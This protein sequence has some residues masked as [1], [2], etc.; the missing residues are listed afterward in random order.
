MSRFYRAMRLPACVGACLLLAACQKTAPQEQKKEPPEVTVAVPLVRPVTPYEEFTGTTEAIDAVDVRARVSGFL[1]DI[2]FTPG[3]ELTAKDVKEKKVLFKI[4]PRPYDV[5]LEKAEAEVTAAKTR[6]ARLR[7]EAE[8]DK[9]LLDKKTISQEEHDRTQAAWQEAEAALLAANATRDRAKLDVTYT[10]VE[11][12]MAGRLSKNLIS[13]GNLVTA[14]ATLLTTIVAIEKMYAYFDVDERRFLRLQALAS[15][16]EADQAKREEQKPDAKAEAKSDGDDVIR[17]FMAI[18]DSK[19]Y[20]YKGFLNFAEPRVNPETGTKQVRAEFENPL[21]GKQSRAL[22]PGLFVRLRVPVD[23]PKPAILVADEAIASAQGQKYVWVIDDK[24]IA[25]R[26]M[27]Q[28]GPLEGQL[29]VIAQGLQRDER[30]VVNGLQK[31]RED[32]AVTP[33]AGK[34]P[35][36]EP[37]ADATA[38]PQS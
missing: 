4:D 37:Q 13:K 31:V 25:R 11:A 6:A 36:D 30:V 2:G 16:Y 24:N 22:T 9:K 33:K 17:A 32:A 1:I 8:R 14:D 12:P 15:E 3:D 20:R 21:I 34:M 26:R 28:L 38:A 7:L 23:D 18:G 10:R 29:R 27:V 5:A 19:D 35:G